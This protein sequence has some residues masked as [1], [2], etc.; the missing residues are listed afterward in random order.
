MEVLHAKKDKAIIE[1]A[2]TLSEIMMNDAKVVHLI[3]GAVSDQNF[4]RISNEELQREFRI[5]YNKNS[6]VISML[7]V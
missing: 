3:Q 6:E 7:E 4:P 2:T 1:D 5:S